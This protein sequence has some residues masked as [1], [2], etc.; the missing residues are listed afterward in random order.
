M[1]GAF[2][3]LCVAGGRLSGL[4]NWDSDGDG[5]GCCDAGHVCDLLIQWNRIVHKL[6]L[7][8]DPNRTS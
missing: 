8:A 7:G 3:H 1:L 4:A 5:N 6:T 2:N